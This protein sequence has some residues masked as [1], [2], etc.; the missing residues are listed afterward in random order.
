MAH[1]TPS[2]VSQAEAG[3]DNGAPF[4]SLLRRLRLLRPDGRPIA[5]P[6]LATIAIAWVP[7]VVL[8]LISPGGASVLKNF[9]I[10]ARFLVAVPLLFE[11]DLMLRDLGLLAVQHF[12]EDRVT[13]GRELGTLPATLRKAGRLRTSAL[14]EA[15][16]LAI[17]FTIGQL[18]IWGVGASAWTLH[19]PNGAVSAP[20][21][22]YGFIALPIFSFLFYRSVWRWVVWGWVLW[23]FARL[24][25]R[26][27]ATHPDGC[28]GLGPLAIPLRAFA[29]ILAAVSAGVCGAWATQVMYGGAALRSF[30]VPLAVLV[31]LGLLLGLGP[32]L[33]FSRK[34]ARAK[35]VGR[36]RYDSLATTYT[37][38]F[39]ERWIVNGD[40]KESLLG[41]ADI[42]SLADLGNSYGTVRRMRIT[43]FDRKDVLMLVVAQ[44]V[45]LVPLLLT[46]VPLGEIMKMLA[47]AVF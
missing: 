27:I 18:S 11:A 26:L 22:W 45:P 28:G 17:G 37:T 23:R 47:K 3:L 4:F 33:T 46:V 40:N 8:A 43:P 34:L 14:A 25:L 9:A 12:A 41:S 19:N 20:A 7:L 35:L 36:L 42:Q 30:A 2:Q 10:H 32:L 24:D 39:D 16:C 1:A 6:A 13:E 29:M 38:Q 21:I 15:V 44:L 5:R 31:A